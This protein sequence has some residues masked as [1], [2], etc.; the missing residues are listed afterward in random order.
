MDELPL[1][2]LFSRLRQAGLPLRIED[3]ETVLRAIQAGYGLPDQEALARLCRTVWVRSQDERHLFDYYF[4]QL[5]LNQ[6]QQSR[7]NPKVKKLRWVSIGAIVGTVFIAVGI[8]LWMNRPKPSVIVPIPISVPPSTTQATPTV[9]P[10][11]QPQSRPPEPRIPAWTLLCLLSLI[12]SGVGLWWVFRQRKQ[13][14]PSAQANARTKALSQVLQ[15]MNDEVQ[16]AQTIQQTVHHSEK[17]RDRF[18]VSNDF[19]PVTR[20]QMKQ[21][22]R[23]LRQLVR[24]ELPTELEVDATV[25]HIAR[26]GILLEPVLVPPRINRTELVLLIDQEGSMVAF[27]SLA[28]RLIETAL[29][30]GKLGKTNIYYFHNCPIHYLYRDRFHLEA[31]PIQAILARM[32]RDRT[33]VLIFSDAGAARGG[34][35]VD[36]VMM[37]SE[38]LKQLQ[39]QVKRVSWLNPM[40]EPRWFNSPAIEIARL[41]PMFEAT[42]QGLDQAIS[43]LRGKHYSARGVLGDRE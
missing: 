9:Q 4:D 39:Q 27:R 34:L 33:V 26:C 11:A 40:P 18:A 41:V 31:E 35:N 1:L 25:Q 29:R 10:T 16:V 21:S 30:G 42:R 24:E 17:S 12:A 3:Y 36:R 6:N 14:Q 15:E 7:S 43:A 5:F 20:R 13:R 23:Y 2:E 32:N 8:A 19:L 22:W 37:T 28:E 38:F